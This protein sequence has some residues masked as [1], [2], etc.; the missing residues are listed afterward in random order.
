MRGLTQSRLLRVR[1]DA[2]IHAVRTQIRPN[3]FISSARE[4]QQGVRT[5][6]RLW[7]AF[8]ATCAFTGLS[9]GELSSVV[10]INHT[11]PSVKMRKNV[12][13]QDAS[14]PARARGSI[15]SGKAHQQGGMTGVLL[16]TMSCVA[17]AT[18]D[19]SRLDASTGD[20]LPL[21]PR[22]TISRGQKRTR[23]S[24]AAEQTSASWRNRRSAT[25]MLAGR[26]TRKKTVSK[27]VSTSG[28]RSC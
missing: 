22:N 27:S 16:W 3:A 12:P 7:A 2:H 26:V 1:D 23:M 24:Q 15:A 11:N 6:P 25:M 10:F 18:P 5:G 4:K 28:C 13:T 20:E 21:S 8:F 19:S 14:S 9:R 17:H